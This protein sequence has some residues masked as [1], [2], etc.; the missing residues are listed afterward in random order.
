MGGSHVVVAH[1][2]PGVEYVDTLTLGHRG[3]RPA[4]H[5]G[6][7]AGTEPGCICGSLDEVIGTESRDSLTRPCGLCGRE[8]RT[9]GPGGALQ[10]CDGSARGD[11]EN[12]RLR[13]AMT[14]QLGAHGAGRPLNLLVIEGEDL[15]ETEAFD[16][17]QTNE[18]R[19]ARVAGRR[20]QLGN[21]FIGQ[22]LR[23]HTRRIP[24]GTYLSQHFRVELLC[25]EGLIGLAPTVRT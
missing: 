24:R 14:I 4:Q 13:A 16:K 19:S 1:A 22:R 21:L 25:L 2:I 11:V 3:V 20:Q 17:E 7:D 12:D 5:V 9:G 6:R 15:S 23:R 18:Q 10:G 8:Q